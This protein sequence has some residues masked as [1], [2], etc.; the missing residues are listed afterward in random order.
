MWHKVIADKGAM[1]IA[2]LTV[3]DVP[4]A[5]IVTLEVPVALVTPVSEAAK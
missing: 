3:N 5:L 1:M 4:P 2:T